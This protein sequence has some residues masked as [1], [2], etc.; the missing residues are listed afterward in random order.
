MAIIDSA[1][2]LDHVGT[3]AILDTYS[4]NNTDNLTNAIAAYHGAFKSAALKRGYS[5]ATIDALAVATAPAFWKAVGAQW[6]LGFMTSGDGNR[7][8]N[9]TK[10][11]EYANQQLG[12]L[13]GGAHTVDELSV[14]AQV[15]YSMPDTEIF[16]N[17]DEDSVSYYRDR[18][19]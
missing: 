18:D 13:A 14:T 16:D 7:S 15:F 17:S 5:A 9:I 3:Q 10:G 12:L 1:Y 19:L 11:W 2:L 4:K 8:D 6:V